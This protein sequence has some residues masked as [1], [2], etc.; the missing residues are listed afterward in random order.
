MKISATPK[1]KAKNK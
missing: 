1:V